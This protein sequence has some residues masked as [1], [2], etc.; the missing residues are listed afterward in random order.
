MSS[1]DIEG[2]L[3][4]DWNF[5]KAIEKTHFAKA[6]VVLVLIGEKLGQEVKKIE[7][8]ENSFGLL[9]RKDDWVRKR[10]GEGSEMEDTRVIFRR[11]LV[12]KDA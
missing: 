10:G 2:L 4:Q 7:D 6:Q 12:L 1:F 3:S 5:A 8:L 9:K 11:I